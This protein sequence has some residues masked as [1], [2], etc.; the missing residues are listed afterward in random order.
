MGGWKEAP[1]IP[2]ASQG[3]VDRRCTP[4]PRSTGSTSGQHNSFKAV[5]YAA[6]LW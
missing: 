4:E 6:L 3:P 1:V 5:C 2:R